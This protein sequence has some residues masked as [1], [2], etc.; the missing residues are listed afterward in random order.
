[1]IK[2]Y[3]F[4]TAIKGFPKEITMAIHESSG[5]VTIN[6][7]R[8]D[9]LLPSNMV[10]SI[11]AGESASE[12]YS[13]CTNIINVAGKSSLREVDAISEALHQILVSH[14][15]RCGRLIFADLLIYV[16][17]CAHI[18]KAAGVPISDVK[19]YYSILLGF[20]LKTYPEYIKDEMTLVPFTQTGRYTT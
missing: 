11:Q 1:M 5:F 7:F 20:A 9:V 8:P 13:D 10:V 19:Q 14:I 16:D 6:Q 3:T 15:Q 17:C 4:K 12:F 2:F 18:I